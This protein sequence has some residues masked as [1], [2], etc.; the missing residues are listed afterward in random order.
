MN[1]EPV[2]RAIEMFG[3]QAKLAKQAN[4]SQGAISKWIRGD[5]IPTG[6]SA[7]LIE[8]ATGGLVTR[9]ELRPDIFN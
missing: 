8:I 1:I 4:L 2:K 5:G 3:S 9:Q 6:E 7:K